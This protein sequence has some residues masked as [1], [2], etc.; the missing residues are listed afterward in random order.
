MSSTKSLKRKASNGAGNGKKRGPARLASHSPSVASDD[1]FE[2]LED[3]NGGLEDEN[4]GVFE[5]P[6]IDPQGSSD[7]DG[8][9]EENQEGEL[10]LGDDRPTA[11]PSRPQPSTKSLYKAPTLSEMEALRSIEESGGT[12]FS[13][14]LST[15]LSSTLLPS[16]P[17]TA[18]KNLL[19]TLHSTI[20]GMSPLP[21]LTPSK[22]MKRLDTSTMPPF[23]GPAEFSLNRKG[24]EVKWTLGWDKPE[25]ILVGGSWGVVGGYKKGKGEMGGVDLVVV[26]PSSLFSPKDRLDYRYFHKRAHYLAV[27]YGQI[28]RLAASAGTLRGVSVEWASSNGDERRPVILITAGKGQGLKQKLDIRIHASVSPNFLPLSTLSPA[29]ALIRTETPTPT[30]LYSTSILHDTLHKS[31]LLHLH[32]LS[33]RLSPDRTVDSYLAAWRIWAHRR[34]IRRERGAS[35][36]FAS[37][38]LGWV[39]DGGEVGGVGGSREK[40]KKVRGVGKGLGHWGALRAAWE[41][42]AHTD[43]EQTPVFIDRTT[44]EG[45]PHIDFTRSFD[46]VLVDPTGRVNIFAGWER[47]DIQLLRHHARQTLAMLEDESDDRFADVFLRQQSLGPEVFDD[48]IQVDI[49]SARLATDTSERSECP[50]NVDVAVFTIA[51]ILRRGL[52]DRAKLVHI[53]PS[54]SDRMILAIGVILNPEHATRVIDIGPSSDQT[55][56]AEEFRNLWGEKAELRRFKDGNIAESVVW[57]LSRPEDATLIPGRIVRC[58]LERH[59]DLAGDAVKCLSSS[60]DWLGMV[61]VPPSARDAVSLPSSE[62]QGFRPTMSAYDALYRLLKDI[63]SELPLAILNVTPSSEMLRYSSTFV[64]HP[65]DINRLPSAPAC[66][67]FVPCADVLVQFESSSRWPDDLAAIQK[68]KLALFDKLARVIT[69]RIADATIGI[70]FDTGASDIE[71]QAGLEVMLPD[72]VAFRLRIYHEKERNLLERIINEDEPVFATS[73][74][75]PPRRLAVPALDLH[76]R[77]FIHL[78]QHHASVAPMHHRFPSY[79]SATRLLKRWFAA[80]LLS[81]HVPAEVAELMLAKVYLDP[82]AVQVPS[83]AVS[84]FLR[85][86]DLLSNWDWKLEPLFVP[87]FTASREG[88]NASSSSGRVR[89]PAEIKKE[90]SKEFDDLRSKEKATDGGHPWVIVT[91]EDESGLRWTRGISKVVAGRVAVLAKA[92][93]GAVQTA[94]EVGVLDVKSLFITPL[95]G[96]DFLLHLH[97]SV[98]SRYSLA[99]SPNSQEWESKL[100]FRNLHSY[101]DSSSASSLT[102]GFDPAGSFV[103]DLQKVYGDEIVWFWDVNGGSVIGGLWNPDAGREGGRAMK[104]FLG[105]SS[106]PVESDSALVKVNKD[107]MLGEIARLGKG[108]I[109]RIE[110]RR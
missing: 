68:L 54:S 29:K 17:S 31:H 14:Q 65:I 106:E 76:I 5:D 57:D 89:F 51:N 69:S 19:S 70:V 108:L 60:Q 27:I 94:T 52:S 47:C 84:G 42:L 90:A 9:E 36:W 49:S 73:L 11:G 91:E 56:A 18:L 99:V 46:N 22:A 7:E 81:P 8:D 26:M 32:R 4:G 40:V 48:F 28:R 45:L 66:I 2:D 109:E 55:E 92:T 37:M 33:Q 63:D 61:Q 96:Y 95:A 75:R 64:P 101:S 38:I 74:P 15:L 78:P 23:A 41:F 3:E 107:A 77:R 35:G 105:W 86:L 87:I 103:K 24:E 110:R 67:N 6:M 98:L 53:S 88:A 72:G 71:D 21:G 58:L 104:A 79:S 16:T 10:D 50:S 80:H 25:E 44:E 1:G 100:K 93:I 12:A 30:P 39:V 43:F 59:F 13:L 97:P 34:G 20:S 83:G 62:K 82:G 102:I 85:A